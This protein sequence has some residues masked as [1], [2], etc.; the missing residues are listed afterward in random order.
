MVL[1]ALALHQP[2]SIDANYKNLNFLTKCCIGFAIPRPTAFCRRRKVE[3]KL[4]DNHVL[5]VLKC[6]NSELSCIK[7]L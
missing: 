4:N 2:P 1:L 5:K 7:T 3:D 6:I